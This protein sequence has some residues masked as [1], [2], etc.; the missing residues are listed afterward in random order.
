MVV[1]ECKRDL[2]DEGAE[3]VF[4]YYLHLEKW[5]DISTC[6][7]TGPAIANE[8]SVCL[9]DK[10]PYRAKKSKTANFPLVELNAV[11]RAEFAK[12]IRAPTLDAYQRIIARGCRNASNEFAAKYYPLTG[13]LAKSAF[14]ELAEERLTALRESGKPSA[15]QRTAESS[16]PA[17]CLL[18]LDID[19]FKQV[20][21]SYGHAYGDL[22][23]K[24]FAIRFEH[25]VRTY[26]E[27]RSSRIQATCAHVSGEEFFCIAW[28]DADSRE[29]ADLAASILE[30]VR[31]TALPSDEE[32]A[33]VRGNTPPMELNVPPASV[34]KVTCSIGGVIH[35][36]PT[37]GESKMSVSKLI[38]QADVALYKSKN[39]GRDRVTFFS[40]ILQNGGRV[41]EYRP[42]LHVCILDIG[43][44]IGVTKGQ[45]FLVYHPEFTGK[46]AYVRDDG[47]SRKVL[48]KLPRIPL[49]TITVFDVQRDIS[50]CRVSSDRFLDTEIPPN[51]ALEAIPLGT[52]S[53]GVNAAWVWWGDESIASVASIPDTHQRIS[54]EISPEE[55]VSFVVIGIRNESQLLSDYG[56]VAINRALV[57]ACR[58]LQKLSNIEF[59][60]QVEPTKLLLKM[61]SFEATEDAA[62]NETLGRAE[63]EDGGRAQFVAG[64]YAAGDYRRGEKEPPLPKISNL[65][66]RADLAR[67][68]ASAEGALEG[69]RVHV[70]THNSAGYL[71]WNLQKTRQFQRGL[72]DY[73]RLSEIGISD[74][75]LDNRAGLLAYNLPDMQRAESLFLKAAD[76]APGELVYLMNAITSQVAQGNVS[77][78]AQTADRIDKGAL[79]QQYATNPWGVTNFAI[80]IAERAIASDSNRSPEAEI[81]WV[82][83]ALDLKQSG[84]MHARLDALLKLLEQ[85]LGGRA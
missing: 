17:L 81:V 51:S 26:C 30:A 24:A 42:E 76:R 44:D 18:A 45:E 31:E 1:E 63:K 62:L 11:V 36:I 12:P 68:A 2:I 40:T 34:R 43:T 52:L 29:F 20:N 22:V 74:A 59:I 8:L 3:Q 53:A 7:Q 69:L 10:L 78:A 71:L 33:R 9:T 6:Q 82:K 38:N 57:T 64:V 55:S 32:L 80:A 60:G 49:C 58:H 13:L 61:P 84:Q 83:R 35:G 15:E 4:G 75:V 56:N 54:G 23:L 39:Q 14:T 19:H 72:S 46:E 70:F 27:S 37:A 50:F 5:W 65:K 21:D 77:A 28:G 66:A 67:Y 79:E 48:G 25:A 41:I 47:R 85:K 73:D 16:L